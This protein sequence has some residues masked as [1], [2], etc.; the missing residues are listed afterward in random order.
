M[1]LVYKHNVTIVAIP[2]GIKVGAVTSVDG[3]Y[4]VTYSTDP[5]IKVPSII[6][7]GSAIFDRFQAQQDYVHPWFGQSFINMHPNY[8]LNQQ[9]QCISTLSMQNNA[10]Q[11][12]LA[13]QLNAANAGGIGLGSTQKEIQDEVDKLIAS[14][15]S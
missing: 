13:G 10:A 3:S 8:S 2:A 11:T 4:L 15:A 6:K 7:P 12:I 5:E 1:K 14:N 9:G